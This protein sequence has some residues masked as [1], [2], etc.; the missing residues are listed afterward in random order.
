[1][2]TPMTLASAVVQITA[3]ASR[4]RATLQGVHSHLLSFVP[5]AQALGG[6]IGGGLIGAFGQSVIAGRAEQM[7][8]GPNAAVSAARDQLRQ[9]RTSVADARQVIKDA[10]AAARDAANPAQLQ[11]ARAGLL[12]SRKDVVDAKDFLANAQARLEAVG[13]MSSGLVAGTPQA[14]QMAYQAQIAMNALSQAQT[15]L[16]AA[17]A[18][19]PAAQAAYLAAKQAAAQGSAQAQAVVQSAHAALTQSLAGVKTAQGNLMAAKQ[20]AAAAGDA[21]EHVAH[22]IA[23][24]ALQASAAVGLLSMLA[25]GLTDLT[26]IGA[27]LSAAE[28]NVDETFGR[29]SHQ[30]REA[31]ERQAQAFGQ[32]KSEYLRYAADVGR[33]LEK[34]GV[35]E[36]VAAQNAVELLDAVQ[37][38]AQA[39]RISF[40][41]AY[42]Q[43]RG[44]GEL[45]TEEQVRAY[46]FKKQFLMNRNNHLNAGAEAL[47]RNLLAMEQIN[48][49]TQETTAAGSTW[50][51][52]MNAIS[53][54]VENLAGLIG[55]DLEP[56][57]VSFL[58]TVNGWIETVRQNWSA[59]RDDIKTALDILMPAVGV[60]A[61]FRGNAVPDVITPEAVS[62]RNAAA[63][64]QNAKRQAFGEVFGGHGGGGHR[65]GFQGGFAEFTRHIQQSAFSQ[66][67]VKLQNEQLN[68][69]QR[70]AKATED[71]VQMFR[72]QPW[73][74]P[75]NK[76]PLA[77]F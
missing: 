5:A 9:A 28:H 54:N 50:Q 38:L 76:N 75:K 1:M 72:L 48:A 24:M 32:S 12:Q 65:G 63:I 10:Q 57:F 19:V 16:A 60:F 31:A 8:S 66:R 15:Q 25:R 55:E 22:G 40:G 20:A 23:G 71:M 39:R 62:N 47:A 68:A 49:T 67:Q 45:F 4:F 2:P 58:Q 13:R 3:D 77:I 64:E 51:A 36:D 53:G 59:W 6:R 7:L 27:Q 61:A 21:F 46:A 37:R 73:K 34:L 56:T 33:E 43:V 35:R 30:I 69:A 14:N 41:E 11:A 26:R 29:S 52:Q 17:K 42:G 74:D 44:R 18:A 70:T